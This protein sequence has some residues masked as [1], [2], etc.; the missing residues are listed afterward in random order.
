MKWLTPFEQTFIDLGTTY[1]DAK[2]MLDENS[3]KGLEEIEADFRSGALTK[4]EG[5]YVD[6]NENLHRFLEPGAIPE[7]RARVLLD[8]GTCSIKVSERQARNR[9]DGSTML[10]STI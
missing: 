10:P 4:N 7:A 5:L 1:R 8:W 3:R 9:L 2:A 6:Y